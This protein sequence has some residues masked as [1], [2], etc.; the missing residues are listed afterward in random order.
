VSDQENT[1]QEGKDETD[2]EGHMLDGDNPVIDKPD[3]EGHM[4]DADNPVIDKPDVE[5]HML[6]ADMVDAG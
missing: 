4:L 2:V 6:D 3:V 5:G 1:P